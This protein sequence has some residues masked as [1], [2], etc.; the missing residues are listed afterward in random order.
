MSFFLSAHVKLVYPE[1]ARDAVRKRQKKDRV[2]RKASKNASRYAQDVV[3]F[4]AFYVCECSAACVVPFLFRACVTVCLCVC[5][6][7]VDDESH[8]R[9][10]KVSIAETVW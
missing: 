5:E 3:L 4:C 9:H 8:Y 1:E 7:S 10:P 6:G 2:A